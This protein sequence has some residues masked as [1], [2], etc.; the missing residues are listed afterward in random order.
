MNITKS[1]TQH[2]FQLRI[3][4]EESEQL[5]CFENRSNTRESIELKHESLLQKK[6]GYSK[7][8]QAEEREFS[9]GNG[10]TKIL[11]VSERERT[12]KKER[13]RDLRKKKWLLRT[14][15]KKEGMHNKHS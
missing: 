7:S 13:E 11:P 2:E 3:K 10:K 12:R 1:L 8:V 6:K 4:P 15:A 5:R 14:V 9:A